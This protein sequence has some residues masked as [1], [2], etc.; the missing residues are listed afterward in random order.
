MARQDHRDTSEYRL[1]ITPQFNERGQRYT[2]LFVLETVKSFASFRYDLSV[3]ETL[4]RK[5]IKY[6]ILGLKTPQLSLPATGHA[7]FMREY[8]DLKGTYE[9]VIE[10][11]DGKVSTFSVRIAPQQVRLMNA[12]SQSFISICT[13]RGA[14]SDK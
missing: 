6:K 7:Q 11:L 3:E 14:W 9:V 10:G 2:T 5:T 4:D 13:D 12:P 8:D 1:L